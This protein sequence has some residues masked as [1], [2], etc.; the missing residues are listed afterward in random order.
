MFGF[1]TAKVFTGSYP[2]PLK[3]RFNIFLFY[4]RWFPFKIECYFLFIFL[5]NS[6]YIST[7]FQE[8]KTVV[9]FILIFKH[10]FLKKQ[11]Q[12]SFFPL[13]A[14]RYMNPTPSCYIIHPTQH[15]HLRYAY[16]TLMFVLHRPSLCC[17]QLAGLTAVSWNV[18]FNLSGTFISHKTLEA[19]LHFKPPRINSMI[20]I[21]FY[22]FVVLYYG[23]KIFKL[24]NL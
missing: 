24:C 19:L 16:F 4:L 21:N 3:P 13:R 14:V 11:Q 2:L 18:P 17:I 20:Y 9:R 8:S 10:V 1:Y 15:H 12:S 5:E 6:K 22:F 23:S 7:R